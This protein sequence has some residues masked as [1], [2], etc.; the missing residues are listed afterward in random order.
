MFD[1]RLKNAL[2]YFVFVF[3]FSCV[4]MTKK[5]CVEGYEK[6]DKWYLE[7]TRLAGDNQEAKDAIY[8]EYLKKYAELD[9][10][11]KN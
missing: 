11:C 10:K 1:F 7:R 5:E 4:E 3:S 6:A 2:L 9:D 8:K